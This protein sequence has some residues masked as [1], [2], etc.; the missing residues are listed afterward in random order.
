MGP[1][2]DAEVS[3]GPWGHIGWAGRCWPVAALALGWGSSPRAPGMAQRVGAWLPGWQW[4][5]GPQACAHGT[6]RRPPGALAAAQGPPVPS[7]L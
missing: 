5:W 1:G 7:A 4:H 3:V 6:H 2:A